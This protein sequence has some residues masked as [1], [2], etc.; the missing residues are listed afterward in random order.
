[1]WMAS[2]NRHLFEKKR[3]ELIAQGHGQNLRPVFF[4]DVEWGNH[5]VSILKNFRT[6]WYLLNDNFQIHYENPEEFVK[7]VVE[8]LRS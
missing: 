1:M 2:V 6:G 4:K 7:M 8:C 3:S 5:F